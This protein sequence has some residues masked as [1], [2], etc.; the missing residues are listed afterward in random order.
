M[1]Q[2]AAPFLFAVCDTA[3]GMDGRG[4]RPAPTN[5]PR[6]SIKSAVSAEGR[7][8][9]LTGEGKFPR[10]N[11]VEEPIASKTVQEP[12]VMGLDVM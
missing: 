7:E 12:E 9:N 2:G 11:T 4:H 10:L 1:S 8:K 3:D 5:H 6:P